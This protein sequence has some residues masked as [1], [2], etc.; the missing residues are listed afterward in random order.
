MGW[1]S[2]LSTGIRVAGAVVSSLGGATRN[3]SGKLMFA[4]VD[5]NK[6]TYLGGVKIVREGDNVDLINVD[7]DRAWFL[8]FTSTD[9]SGGGKI[10]SMFVD[11]AKSKIEPRI[12]PVG[13]QLLESLSGAACYSAAPVSDKGKKNIQ[14]SFSIKDWSNNK[15]SLFDNKFGI[16]LEYERNYF[17]LENNYSK[18]DDVE[19]T[20]ISVQAITNDGDV[21]N[22]IPD[23]K[24][25]SAADTLYIDYPEQ[26]DSVTPLSR[27][28]V[29]LSAPWK[30]LEADT[31]V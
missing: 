9:N 18:E 12:E 23:K 19:F 13:S 31:P 29:T 22:L 4:A 28:T 11:A 2:F 24:V 17:I 26:M 21:Y 20:D 27:V 8:T 5:E 6:E 3:S 30:A 14:M 15:L 25:L 1:L 10:L 7:P 16:R